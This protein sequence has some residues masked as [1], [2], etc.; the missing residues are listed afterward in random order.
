M[1]GIGYP[2]FDSMHGFS[3]FLYANGKGKG[4]PFD[5]LRAGKVQKQVLK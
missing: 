1:N 2:V 3:A 5:G 4:F